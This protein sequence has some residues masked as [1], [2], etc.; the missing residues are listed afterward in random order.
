MRT[1]LFSAG[2]R[3]IWGLPL[4]YEEGPGGHD[5][6]SGTAGIQRVIAWLPLKKKS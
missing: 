4:T 3:G 2:T 6:P 1:I 5:G